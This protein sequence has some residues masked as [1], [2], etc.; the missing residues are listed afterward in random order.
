[1]YHFFIQFFYKI[2]T[3]YYA[4]HPI[5]APNIIVLLYIK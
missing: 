1:M 2:H 5:N 3:A 4:E